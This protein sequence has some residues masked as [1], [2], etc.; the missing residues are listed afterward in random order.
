[1]CAKYKPKKENRF[2]TNGIT[3]EIGP[4]KLIEGGAQLEVSSKIPVE[5]VVKKGMNVRYFREIRD[6]M[7]KGFKKP[8]DTRMENIIRSN[9]VNEIK[10]RDYVKCVFSYK[11]G[12]LY[13]EAEVHKVVKAASSGK[14]DLSGIH[15]VTTLAGRAVIHLI[16]RNVHEVAKKNVLDMVR[17]N[18]IL[19]KR[20]AK[21]IGR[22]SAEVAAKIGRPAV[23][24]AKTTAPKKKAA[25]KPAPMKGRR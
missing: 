24:K 12:E 23:V 19:L 16:N 11:N 21:L 5:M 1:M 22:I 10:E 25:K 20:H 8:A 7:K 17:A 4:G 14:L 9:N 15:G 13:D 3:Y 18:E 2:F 6:I